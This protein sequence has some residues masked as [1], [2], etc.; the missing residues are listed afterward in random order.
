MGRRPLIKTGYSSEKCTRFSTFHGFSA[1]NRCFRNPLFSGI[2]QVSESYTQGVMAL[3]N[4]MVAFKKGRRA[5][6]IISCGA[7]LTTGRGLSAAADSLWR[8]SGRLPVELA[9][10]VVPE[11]QH[12]VNQLPG[13]G[14][15]R[16]V[17][18]GTEDFQA[19]TKAQAG[20]GDQS[21]DHV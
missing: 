1:R 8:L 13:Q 20:F 6:A 3:R 19:D 18:R 10:G 2:F 16:T 9:L 5:A 15:I 7:K 12:L 21:F 4:R 11:I 17:S 14:S